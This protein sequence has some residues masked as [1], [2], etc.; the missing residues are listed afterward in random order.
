MLLIWLPKNKGM[1]I[2]LWHTR[3]L[4]HPQKETKMV[5]PGAIFH[6]AFVPLKGSCSSH[7]LP[8]SPFFHHL[9]LGNSLLQFLFSKYK[10]IL[11]SSPTPPL[12]PTSFPFTTG[13]S[14]I[15]SFSLIN[16]DVSPQPLSQTDNP[17]SGANDTSSEKQRKT[18]IF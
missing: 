7:N 18:F 10:H 12:F 6:R 2:Y 4:V 15:S 5:D 8:P 14:L 13:K 1:V 17:K 9:P 11:F 16:S 3:L